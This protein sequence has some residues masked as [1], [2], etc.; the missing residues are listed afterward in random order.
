MQHYLPHTDDDIREMLDRIGVRD[1]N[2]LLTTVPPE[3]LAKSKLKLPEGLSEL[4][5]M[6]RVKKLSYLN[7]TTECYACFMG[8]GAYDHFVPAAV[9]AILSRSEFYTAYTPYQAEV[10]QGTLQAIYEYQTLI[11][12]LTGMDAANAS[13][14]D[15]A[16][17]L[18]EAM[19]VS[20]AQAR[21]NIILVSQGVHPHYVEVLR[22]YAHSAKIEIA[23][24]PLVNGVTDPDF[25]KKNIAS[26]ACLMLQSP[27]FLGFIEDIA[28]FSDPVHAA[29]ALLVVSADPISLG[30]LEAPGKLGAD[31]VTGEGQGLGNGLNFGGPYLGIFAVKKE[32]V[33]RVPG[34]LIGATTD[35]KG[36]RGFVMTLQTREQH[37]R[38]EKATSNICTNQALCALAA[39][40]TLELLGEEGFKELADLCLQKAHYLADGMAAIDGFSIPHK[41]PFFK[42]FPVLYKGDTCKLLGNLSDKGF[43]LGPDLGRFHPD[44]KGM[45]L[46]AVTEKR[47][48]EEMDGLIKTMKAVG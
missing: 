33:R 43:L 45:F 22:T 16:T 38:R 36:R 47:T 10:S 35:S 6:D 20:C 41:Q 3:I 2:E 14:Y 7:R 4:E 19:L 12:R 5:A 46:V 27:N 15:G 31:I 11:C 21:R 37:I 9:D 18:A 26:A 24:V 13:H 8:G 42:E 34:R 29:K 44:W 48:K 25:V 1:F 40:I 39:C 32:L 30:L 23:I 17:A 28:V